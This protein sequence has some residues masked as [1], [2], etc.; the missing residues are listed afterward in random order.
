MYR[1]FTTNQPTTNKSNKSFKSRKDS[2]VSDM[3]YN[4]YKKKCEKSRE[5]ATTTSKE[6]PKDAEYCSNCSSSIN[7]S[8]ITN[9]DEDDIA[10]KIADSGLGTCYDR[11]SFDYAPSGCN[12]RYMNETAVNYKFNL[13]SII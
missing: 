12:K 2:G 5:P 8:S 7:D 3:T 9:D 1:R 4:Y 13:F 11:Q 6:C 10:S